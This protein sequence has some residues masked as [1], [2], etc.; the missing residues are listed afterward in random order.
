LLILC[1]LDSVVVNVMDPWISWLKTELGYKGTLDDITEWQIDKVVPPEIGKKC[2]NFLK[3]PDIFRNLKAYDGALDGLK[4]LKSLGH[5]IVI[6]SFP[7]VA[8]AATDKFLWVK[9]NLPWLS[10]E[11]VILTHRKSMIKADVLI[12]DASHNLVAHRKVWGNSVKLITIAWPYN[13]EGQDIADYVGY[14]Y[15]DMSNAWEGICQHLT[16]L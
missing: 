9:E 11:D 7:P 8:Q 16:Y 4:Y 15:R 13:A 10:K 1:D 6:A 5:D 12:D 3:Q 14:D 2:Y